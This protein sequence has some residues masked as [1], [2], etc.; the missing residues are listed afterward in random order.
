MVTD[1]HSILATWRSHSS[2]LFNVHGVNDV[3]RTEIHSAELIVPETYD[4]E[5]KKAI[6]KLKRHKTPGTEQIPA[7]FIKTGGRTIRFENH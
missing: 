5:A 4:F 7:E 2:Q 1:S 3:R 6:E